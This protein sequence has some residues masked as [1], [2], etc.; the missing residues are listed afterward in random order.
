MVRTCCF[1]WRPTITLLS[2]ANS[3]QSILP[4]G[5]FLT[6]GSKIIYTEN[7]DGFSTVESLAEAAPA[8]HPGNPHLR[9]SFWTMALDSSRFRLGHRYSFKRSNGFNLGWPFINTPASAASCPSSI[10][11]AS[12]CHHAYAS[13]GDAL[14]LSENRFRSLAILGRRCAGLHSALAHGD[15]PPCLN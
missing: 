3:W 4:S 14:L 13:T 11:F 12:H 1:C 9:Y 8:V 2:W 7:L 15:M 6:Y 10:S 5:G